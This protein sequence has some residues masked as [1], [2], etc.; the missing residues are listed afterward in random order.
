MLRNIISFDSLRHSS[1]FWLHSATVSMSG[2]PGF[3]A[4]EQDVPVSY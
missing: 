1:A 3:R 4:G 2:L